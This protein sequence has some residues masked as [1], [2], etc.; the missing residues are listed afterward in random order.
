MTGLHSTTNVTTMTQAFPSMRIMFQGPQ[1][2][3]TL[4]KMQEHLINCAMT[5]CDH[6]KRHMDHALTDCLYAM[7]SPNKAQDLRNNIIALVDPIFLQI[8]NTAVGMW[9][10]TTPFLQAA[11]LETLKAPWHQTEGM[12]KRWQKIQDTVAFAVAAN[13]P[14][15]PEQNMDAALICICRTQAYK[16]AYLAYR[17]LP[18]QNYTTLHA[19]FEQAGR[20][21]NKVEDKAAMNGYGMMTATEA[22][23]REMQ[24]GLAD[25]AFA[26]TSI[27]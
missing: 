11:N 9:E 22:A 18:L 7:L 26:L 16:Q 3:K 27:V 15:P 13:A 25:V 2:L 20:D 12:A 8:C 4:L 24:K 5:F 14:I 1:T 19:H 17:R 23:D 21:R 6:N 10:H